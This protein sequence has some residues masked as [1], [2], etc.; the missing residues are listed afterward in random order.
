MVIYPITTY[1]MS[2]YQYLTDFQNIKLC[3]KIVHLNLVITY[4]K[5]IDGDRNNF[6]DS[7]QI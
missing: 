5:V 7:K 6:N 4:E 3:V 2:I 1:V